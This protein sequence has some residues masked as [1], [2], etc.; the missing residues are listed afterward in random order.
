MKKIVKSQHILMKI[1]KKLKKN[2]LLNIEKELIIFSK[3]DK[4][5]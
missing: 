3:K 1:E 2:D 5:K 4:I